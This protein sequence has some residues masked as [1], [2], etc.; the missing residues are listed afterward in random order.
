MES[1]S[2]ALAVGGRD[3]VQREPSVLGVEE[4]H[5]Q[6]HGSSVLLR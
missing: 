1:S 4:G 5:Q 6:R 3:G 2:V